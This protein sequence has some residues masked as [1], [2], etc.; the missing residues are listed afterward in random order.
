[1][2]TVREALECPSDQDPFKVFYPCC[3]RIIR[4]TKKSRV[5]LIAVTVLGKV[6]AKASVM[7]WVT[8]W[9]QE[10]TRQREVG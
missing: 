2:L 7:L 4:A 10:Q 1:M 5:A 8:I 3:I 9:H 6:L